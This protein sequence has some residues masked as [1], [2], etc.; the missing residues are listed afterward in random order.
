MEMNSPDMQVKLRSTHCENYNKTEMIIFGGA[1]REQSVHWH[2]AVGY[3]ILGVFTSITRLPDGEQTWWCSESGGSYSLVS[4]ELFF[5][6]IR[7]AGEDGQGGIS[8]R[9]SPVCNPAVERQWRERGNFETDNVLGCFFYTLKQDFKVWFFFRIMNCTPLIPFL[10]LTSP[11]MRRPLET[12]DLKTRHWKFSSLFCYS[13]QLYF[14]ISH[15]CR[16]SITV[17]MTTS[18]WPTGLHVKIYQM[19]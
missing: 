9:N 12:V 3:W 18:V 1:G 11:K 7:Q 13:L 6:C 10:I 5:I 4:R 19:A 2:R 14:T 16:I 15:F 17:F 8:P